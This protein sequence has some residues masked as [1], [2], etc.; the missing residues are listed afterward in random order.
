MNLLKTIRE[1]GEDLKADFGGDLD[2][3]MAYEVA[4]CLLEDPE[5]LKEAQKMWPGKSRQILQ[6]MVAD[7]V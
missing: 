3:S 2:D 6:E 5:F 1:A 4:N 7:R